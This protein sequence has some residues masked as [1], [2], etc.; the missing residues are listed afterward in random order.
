M[1]A[2]LDAFLVSLRFASTVGEHV[3]AAGGGGGGGRGG[4]SGGGGSGRG[5]AARR[6]ACAAATLRALVTLRYAVVVREG[7][8]ISDSD[9]P[10]PDGAPGGGG[11]SGHGGVGGGSVHLVIESSRGV[12]R[13]ADLTALAASEALPRIVATAVAFGVP[14]L[15]E[16]GIY[17]LGAASMCVGSLLRVALSQLS[18][19]CYVCAWRVRSVASGP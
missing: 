4:G 16:V 6:L 1:N 12:E 3:A 8:D 9:E 5:P 14:V 10:A 13:V 7:G 18:F 11:G 17:F 2:L 19:S 15:S